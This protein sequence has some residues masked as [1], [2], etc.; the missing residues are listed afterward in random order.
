MI[1]RGR[2][3]TKLKYTAVGKNVECIVQKSGPNSC[4][5][6]LTESAQRTPHARPNREL[7]LA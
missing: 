5:R 6:P 3:K 4:V 1:S 7:M 2:T